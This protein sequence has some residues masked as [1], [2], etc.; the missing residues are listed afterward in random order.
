MGSSLSGRFGKHARLDEKALLF[1]KTMTL[2][3]PSEILAVGPVERVQGRK[4]WVAGTGL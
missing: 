3:V 2:P 4:Y 1:L